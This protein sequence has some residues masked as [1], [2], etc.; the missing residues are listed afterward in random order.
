VIAFSRRAS[1]SLVSK[2]GQG[3]RSVRRRKRTLKRPQNTTQKNQE[4][5]GSEGKMAKPTNGSRLGAKIMVLAAA[6]LPTMAWAQ[7]AAPV[8][9][10][11]IVVTGTSI[12]GAPPVGG[13]LLAVGREQIEETGA[14]NMQQI[15]KTV[16]AITGLGGA[17]VG[18]NAG[19]SYYAP[20]IHQLGAS[21][22]NSTLT[23]IDGHR[24]PLGHLS[25]A[26]PDPG[27]LPPIAIERVEVLAEGASATY[28]SDAV[29][30]VVNIITRRRYNGVS[31]NVQQGWG[32][33]YGT[34]S[35]GLL[36]GKVWD[37]GSVMVAFGHS[38]SDAVPY[39]YANR[40]YLQPNHIDEGGT[41]F[42]SFNCTLATVQP[43]GVSN[44]YLSPYTA[45]NVANTAANAP[46][47]NQP[48]G[49]RIGKERRYNG[50]AKVTQE[51]NEALTLTGDFVYSDRETF[52][53][54]SR[55]GIQASIWRT[56]VQANPFY[57]N[58]PGV[59]AGTTAGDRQTIRWQADD[60]LG[61]GAF[62]VNGATTY[63]ATAGAEW[64]MTDKFRVTAAAL[65]GEDRTVQIS[66][67]SLCSSCAALALNGTT[68]T[69]GSMTQ[70]VAGTNLIPLNLPLTIA[71]A[72]DVWNVGAANRT[73]AAVKAALVD[74]RSDSRH[75]S[76]LRQLRAGIDG[77]LFDLPA[78]ALRVAAGVESQDWVLNTTNVR[79]LNTGPASTGSSQR[80]FPLDRQVKSTYGELLIPL[81]SPE[82]QSFLYRV[83]LSASARYDD[84]SDFGGTTNPKVALD[85]EVV[86]GLK[87]RGNWSQSFVAPSMRSIG[88]PINGTASYATAGGNS[89]VVNIPI[90]RFPTVTSIPGITCTATTCAFGGAIQGLTV[91][92]G[93]PNAGPQKGE[94]WSY[95]FDFAPTQVAGLK[96]S[97]TIFN[98]KLRG[99]ITAPC[100]PGCFLNNGSLNKYLHIYPAGATQAEINAQV[101]DV[102]ITSAFPATVYFIFERRQLNSLDLDVQGLD[103]TAGYEF[104]TS[105]GR[106]SAGGSITEFL[107]FDQAFNGGPIFD[108]LNTV[109]VNTTFPAIKRQARLNAGWD[110]QD[111][112][113]EVF[114]N[115]VGS[116]KNVGANT[117]NAVT[118]DANGNFS[119]GGDVIDAWTTYDLHVSYNFSKGG[120]LGN[121]EVYVDVNNVADEPPPFNNQSAGFDAFG[122]N[123]LGRVV[124]VGLRA[125]F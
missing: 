81:I 110:F 118:L 54:N 30:G 75:L 48:F 124:N 39:D 96:L 16:P 20:T 73:S 68:Q 50:Y 67:G 21:A 91:D 6:S 18:Q 44:I 9:D 85:V 82:Q 125:R 77:E 122:S 66:E 3:R 111:F 104:E 27:I 99:G 116:Y 46:C 103:L 80:V 74:S 41:N 17:G 121:S 87:L 119:G 4:I 63:I 29:A 114:A 42:Q 7:G 35:A 36:G 93:N 71:N 102:P 86:Q 37:T 92:T 38:E 47:D 62:T 49:D 79:P 117:I 31:A 1:K 100:A 89:T 34:R 51:I 88:D 11:E 90:S 24:I 109:G 56:G 43:Q 59:V 95:G 113:F 25:L 5:I 53:H 64:R 60:L 83:D 57:V 32:D 10:S 101:N 12:R 23:V 15:L 8:A 26:L 61:P 115:H 98:N 107:K 33:H 76:S 70:V 40:P 123:P 105:V 97:A 72:L 58:P 2:K 19:N 65:Y 28:G 120:K 94:T 69:G 45:T 13:N 106:F 55:G 108:I 84:Y 14:I 52:T 22:S 112:S 78:G